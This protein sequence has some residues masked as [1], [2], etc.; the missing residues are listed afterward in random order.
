MGRPRQ[1]GSGW[2]RTSG[3]PGRPGPLSLCGRQLFLLQGQLRKKKHVCVYQFHFFHM[4]ENTPIH[5]HYK[6]S[7]KTKKRREGS[8]AVGSPS[9]GRGFC[10]F[11]FYGSGVDLQCRKPCLKH[12]WA[13]FP[14]FV[15][16][17][18]VGCLR[19]GGSSSLGVPSQEPP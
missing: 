18:R 15:R 8:Y 2:H 9:Q 19:G 16:A 11:N 1:R 4:T 13:L 17:R 6:N 5:P 3:E 7:D 14:A 10:L 12:I